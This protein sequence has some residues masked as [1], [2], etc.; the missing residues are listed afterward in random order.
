MPTQSL[1]RAH[2]RVAVLL[3]VLGFAAFASSAQTA[4]IPAPEAR[5]VQPI[6]AE[7][8]TVLAGNVHPLARAEYDRGLA[9]SDLR[10]NRMLL[11]LKRGPDQETA[12]RKLLD[13]QQ[14]KSSPNYHAWLTP[15]QFGAT[16]GP[17]DSDIQVVTQWLTSQGFTDIRVGPGR[18]VIEFSGNVAQVSVAFHT[19]IRRFVVNNEDHTANATDPQIPAALAPVVAGI[20]SLHNFPRK[21][22]ARYLGEFQRSSSGS[23]AHPLLTFPTPAGSTFFGMGPS[24][25]AKIYNVQPLWDAGIDGTGQTI[26]IVAETNINLQD[27][28]DFRNAF[29]LPVNDPQIVLNGEDPGIT[30][31]GEESE[32]DL[33]VQWSG[34]VA[35]NATVKFVLSASTPVSSGVD[36]SALYIV[37]NNLAGVMSESY[38]Q[39]EP[40]LGVTGNQFFNDLWKQAAAQ[41]ITVVLSSGDGGSAGCDNFDTQQTATHGLAVSGFASTPYNVSVGGTDFDQINKWTQFWNSTNDPNTQRSAKGYIPEIPWNQTCSQLGITGCGSTAPQGSVNIVAGSGG[42]SSLYAKP[43]WQVGVTGMPNDNHRDQPD[44]SLFASPG[45]T[46]SGYI[47]CQQDKNSSGIRACDLNT[48]TGFLDF[49]AIGGTSASAPAFAGIMALVNQKQSSAQVLAP[50]QGNANYVL[51]ALAKQANSSCTSSAAP[52]ATCTFYDVTKGN[53][54]AQL[55]PGVAT[56]S[57]PCAGGSLNCSAK[58]AGTNGVLVDP[59]KATTEAWTASAGYDLVTGLG[60]VN[61]FNLATNWSTV[62][63]TA[64]AT[65]LALNPTTSITHGS[66]ENVAVTI[67]VTPAAATGNVALLAT[68]PDGSVHSVGVFTLSNGSVSS[69][70]STIPGGISMVSAHYAGDGTF[71]PS[72]SAQIPTTVTPESSKTFIVTPTFDSTGNTTNPNASTVPYGTSFFIRMYV[73]NSAAAVGAS[74]VPAPLCSDVEALLCPGGSVILTDNGSPVGQGTFVLNNAAYTRDLT[75]SLSAFTGGTHTLTARYSGD[76]SFT[77]STATS[78]ITITPVPTQIPLVL[79]PFGPQL[80]KTPLT[81]TATFTPYITGGVAPT[82]TITFLDGGTVIPGPVTLTAADGSTGIPSHITG[83]LTAS[84]ATSGNH[85]ITAQYSGDA[86]YLG[87]LSQPSNLSIVFPTSISQTETSTNINFGQSVTVT[88]KV[89]GGSMNPP[90]AGQLQFFGSYASITETPTFLT[91]TDPSGN[92]VLTATV[93]TSPLASE[94]ISA[95]YSG[96]TNYAAAVTGGD[97]VNVNIPDFTV[98]LPAAPFTVTA[99]QAGVLQISIVPATN[100]TSPVSLACN[101]NLPVGYSCSLQPPT[102]TLANGLASTTMLTI[103][104]GPGGNS[105][106]KTHTKA[107]GTLLVH[108]DLFRIIGLTVC[109]FVLVLLLLPHRDKRLRLALSCG[110][111]CVVGV[112]LGCGGGASTSTVGGGSGGNP[113]P[114]ATTTTVSTSSAKVAPNTPITFTATVSGQGSPTGPVT[115]FI[116]NGVAGTA[117]LS[118]G[119]ASISANLTFAG[120]YTVSAQYTGDAKNTQSTS[121][122]ITQAVTGSTVFDVRAQTGGLI[123]FAPIIVTVQ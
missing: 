3:V 85:V 83:S 78:T 26:A 29:G 99:G 28:R 52:A 119:T 47:I 95:R 18:L 25:F 65:T 56:N 51:Y 105:Q 70:T 71:A 57:V 16:F 10:L 90:L 32:A 6:N 100:S 8:L 21:S 113:G 9:P 44:I 103:S 72:D 66:N 101:G 96:D 93:T 117:N 84:F 115:F 49:H 17:A 13:D 80:T 74:G 94:V 92:Q 91:S 82:G 43:S 7:N 121:P 61:A 24:D 54:F 46:G 81:I 73:A 122:T 77:S 34:A 64:T 33:D 109:V 111:V 55:A 102:V 89:T 30:S 40:V 23:K 118:A 86:S 53:T 63:T 14:D 12:L 108:L 69:T 15:E 79:V 120:V 67:N 62:N 50:R 42:P 36:L 27:V 88:A 5:I 2:L 22:H 107:S 110:A 48:G 112:F 123:H 76:N 38:G 4:Q 11:V 19:Q 104:P 35:K 87:L 114:F 106:L 31:L 98:S 39:C 97:L 60:S 1:C 59:A 68:L 58:T 75:P 41:G 37:E 116:N 20:V 45:F